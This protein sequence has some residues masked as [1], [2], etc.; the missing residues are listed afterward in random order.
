[1]LGSLSR[2]RRLRRVA[3]ATGIGLATGAFSLYFWALPRDEPSDFSWVWYAARAFWSG[4]NP[5]DVIGPGKPWDVRHPLFYPFPAVLIAM[6]FALLPLYWANAVF[7]ALGASSLAW[8]LSVNSLANP[9]L[10]VFLSFAFLHAVEPVQWSPFLTAAALTPSL[11]FMFAAKPTIAAALWIGYPSRRGLQ[12]AMM[13]TLLSLAVWPG[14]VEAWRGVLGA[15][16]HVVPPITR[17]GGPLLLL[18]LLRWRQPEARLLTALACVPQAPFLYEAVP[19]FLIVRRIEEA[20]V[21]CSGTLAVFLIVL[22]G[23][24]YID[25]EASAAAIGQWMVWLLYLPSLVLVLRRHDDSS[26]GARA[27]F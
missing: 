23:G 17:W 13:L 6:P 7:A 8:A 16:T 19:L 18:G 26:G 21:L 2:Q 4:E 15:G 25:Y 14:W 3:F 24:P 11:G 27:E 5:Y 9:R 10:L 1:M 22:H 12:W 20:V